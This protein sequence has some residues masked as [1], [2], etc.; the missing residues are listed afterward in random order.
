MTAFLITFKPASENPDKGWPLEYL[1]N[2]A[3]NFQASGQVTEQWRFA[4]RSNVNIGDRI[5]LLLQGR[6]GPAIIGY[7]VAAGSAQKQEDTWF[8]PIRFESLVDPDHSALSTREELQQI[9][10]SASVW[11]TQKSGIKLS[12]PIALSLEKLVVGRSLLPASQ[13]ASRNPPWT[14]DELILALNLY[15]NA[16]RKWLDE[17]DENVINLSN[18]LQLLA[19]QVNATGTFRNPSG[20]S[21]KLSN[22]LRLDPHYTDK[23]GVG[24]QRGGKLEKEVWDEFADNPHKLAAVAEAIKK[25]IS[26]DGEVFEDKDLEP[27]FMEAPEGR[28]LTRTHI[29]RERNRAIVQQRKQKAIKENGKLICEVCGFDFADKYG[30]RGHGFIE[31]HHTKPLE[32]LPENH[33]TRLEDLSLVCSNCHRMIHAERPW[34]SILQLRSILKQS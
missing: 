33:K 30:D 26:E 14:R 18:D 12:D 24:L 23:G 4:N 22:L 20:V 9:P 3:R 32:T 13:I 19:K 8:L 11:K 7:G 21:M 34:L 17:S 15:M 28:I 16:G 1:Q 5:F 2:L 6:R 29:F 25:T 27:D 10:D 31:C